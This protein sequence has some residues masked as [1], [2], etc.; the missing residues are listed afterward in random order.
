MRCS[1]YSE[2]CTYRAST[3][4]SRYLKY[5]LRFS[6]SGSLL[7]RPPWLVPLRLVIHHATPLTRELIP[8]QYITSLE[9]ASTWPSSLIMMP[10]TFSTSATTQGF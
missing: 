1:L 10:F 8:V 9:R 4:V 5:L 3:E 6:D 2:C 7:R